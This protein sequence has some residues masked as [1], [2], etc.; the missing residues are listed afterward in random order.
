MS[1]PVSSPAH[2]HERPKTVSRV[3][4]PSVSKTTRRALS[5]SAVIQ[6][7]RLPR[8]Q[9]KLLTTRVE[10]HRGHGKRGRRVGCTRY[11]AT[12]SRIIMMSLELWDHTVDV[13]YRPIPMMRPQY[14]S[15]SIRVVTAGAS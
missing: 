1:I 2:P 13:C 10:T 15:K 11:K 14:F 4:V 3:R 5:I 6:S 8:Q 9:H 7:S 12:L